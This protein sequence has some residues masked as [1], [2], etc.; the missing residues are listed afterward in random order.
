MNLVLRGADVLLSVSTPDGSLEE[1]FGW[2]VDF[3]VMVSQ[4]QKPIYVVDTP[5]PIQIAQAASPTGVNGRMTTFFLRHWTL[6]SRGFLPNRQNFVGEPIHYFSKFLNFKIID[7]A[8]RKTIYVF[9]YCKVSDF[10]IVFS[11]RN[12]VKCILNFTGIFAT[13]K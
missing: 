7:R 12:T 4:G 2:V 9:E 3:N 1:I 11:T 5:F 13:P 8:T 10:T 6:E